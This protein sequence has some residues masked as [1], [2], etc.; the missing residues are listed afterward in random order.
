MMKKENVKT[1]SVLK[2]EDKPVE[3]SNVTHNS[4]TEISVPA[5]QPNTQNAIVPDN[6]ENQ[7]QAHSVPEVSTSAE[8]QS[9]PVTPPINAIPELAAAAGK[10]S[11]QSSVTPV[12]APKQSGWAKLGFVLSILAFIGMILG[13]F[14]SFSFLFVLIYYFVL[15]I[16]A[17]LTLFLILLNDT[18]MSYLEGGDALAEM[19]GQ[20]MEI[21]K[22]INI[23]VM[24][25]A[26]ISIVLLSIFKKYPNRVAGLVFSIIALI[27]ALIAFIVPYVI[28]VQ[29]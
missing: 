4:A 5:D 29:F 8:V 22:Y 2:V 12:V 25:M 21:G 24:S 10:S 9:E 13:V 15:I 19:S 11:L 28:D 20:L 7:V 3:A 1:K 26:V 18:F 23:G 16:F 17:M 6:K 14:T 27:G